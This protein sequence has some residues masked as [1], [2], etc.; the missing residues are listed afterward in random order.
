MTYNHHPA[1]M[2]YRSVAYHYH[3]AMINM[4]VVLYYNYP[5]R[6]R[7]RGSNTDAYM[8]LCFGSAKGKY[9]Y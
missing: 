1:V 4:P 7:R 2:I 3:T 5:M 9:S 6:G 8:H